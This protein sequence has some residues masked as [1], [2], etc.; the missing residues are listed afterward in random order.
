MITTIGNGENIAMKVLMITNSQMGYGANNSMMDMMI[1]LREWGVDFIVLLQKNGEIVHE[2]KN[3]NIRFYILSYEYSASTVATC[4][5]KLKKL[6]HN[7]KLLRNAKRIVIENKIDIIH[8]NASNVD[9]GAWLSVVC[10]LP[11]IWH[12]RELMKEDYKLIY[13]FP[14]MEE[15]LMNNADYLI[16]ISNYVKE[17]RKCGKNSIV[18]YNG[19]DIE[20]YAIHKERLFTDEIMHL[21]FCGV[22]S[23]EKGIMDAV[24]AIKK[25][26]R[27]GIYNIRLDIVGKRNS[28]SNRIA[29]YVKDNGLENHIFFHGYKKDMRPFRKNA[30][31][32][33]MCSKS[34]ALGRVTI[35]SMLGE[36]LVIGANRGGTLELIKDGKT[37]YL[38]AAGDVSQLARKI[39]LVYEDLESSTKIVREA[40]KFAQEKFNSKE[41]AQ[42]IWNIYNKCL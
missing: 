6:L 38:Y 22:I 16:P 13:D 39:L 21:L 15:M 1:A 2:L 4:S 34:E 29:K 26:V 23:K 27:W 3:R 12:I 14:K 36:C 19:V 8:T 37:G 42:K 40:K 35:E 24:K 5:V 17:K 10:K 25:I 31:I 41:Y 18:I 33:L 9:F 30:N 32:A 28:Y 11:H 20:K 7:I